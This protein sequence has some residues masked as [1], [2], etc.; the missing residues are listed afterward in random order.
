MSILLPV[1]GPTSPH[2]HGGVDEPPARLLLV[3]NERSSRVR[4]QRSLTMHGFTVTDVGSM[5]DALV[6]AARTRFM[7]AIV[8]VR[9]PDGHGL[10]LLERLLHDHPGMRL[11]VHTD[12]DS[13]ASVVV[14]LRG[15]AIG[16]LTKPAEIGELVEALQGSGSSNDIVPGTPLGVD[17]LCW[18]HVHRIFEQCGRNVSRTAHVMGMHRRTLQRMLG[19]RA[20]RPRAIEPT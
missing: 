14:A 1:A 7:Y 6:S 12:F 16:Y 10:A 5:R 8:E 4:L 18:E 2:V 3:D 17:R 13:F 15:G 11:V 19:K 9:L 20:P